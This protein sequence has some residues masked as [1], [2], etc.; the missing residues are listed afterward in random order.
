MKLMNI[1]CVALFPLVAWGAG[2]SSGNAVQAAPDAVKPATYEK[3]CQIVEEWIDQIA[4]KGALPSNKLSNLQQALK[5]L[6]QGAEG[7][8]GIDGLR[9]AGQERYF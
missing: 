4:G 2:A 6:S 7:T 9:G 5:A 8:Q 1:C 3:A